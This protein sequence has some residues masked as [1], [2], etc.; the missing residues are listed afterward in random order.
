VT[1]ID[2]RP[3]DQRRDLRPALRKL[4]SADSHVTEPL[5]L[6]DRLPDHLRSQAP[7]IEVKDGRTCV[8]V[9]GRILTRFRVPSELRRDTR[10]VDGDA[11]PEGAELSRL[12]EREELEQMMSRAAGDPEQRLNDLDRD[13]I[14]AEVMYPNQLIFVLYRLT[15]V[16]LQIALC[17]LY[18]DWLFDTFSGT[19]RFIPVA[20]LPILDVDA[21]VAELRRTKRKGYRA[22]TLPVH[23]DSC[24]EP[25]NQPSYEPLWA[26]AEELG[27]PLHFHAGSG[28]DQRPAHNP[29]G[30][31]INYVITVGG[32]DETVCY[33]TGSGVLARHPDLRVVMV[34]CGS[35]WLAWVLHAMDDAYRE[36]QLMVDPKLDLLPS[37]YFKRQGAVTFQSDP[38]GM[39]NIPFTGTDCL[40][41]GSDYPHPEGTWPDSHRYLEAQM[42]GFPDEV[43]RAV[44]WDNASRLY[45]VTG[46]AVKAT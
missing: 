29:G 42:A 18:N 25:Y 13:G 1:T 36:H 33:L 15:N 4:I 43:V 45:S 24:P 6:W 26:A 46:P 20:A 16:E 40:M 19:E 27:V 23:T 9:E 22:A 34:E 12:A 21:A 7:H 8:V 28:R 2:Q 30:A 39:N 14:W 37:E 41:W 11:I 31:V 17:R 5:T 32:A 38:V 44:V 35:G 10:W 3:D